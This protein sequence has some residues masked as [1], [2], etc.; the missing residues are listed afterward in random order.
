MT[1][2]NHASNPGDGGRVSNGGHVPPNAP[3]LVLAPANGEEGQ[4]WGSGRV[5][6]G[7]TRPSGAP[8]FTRPPDQ[9]KCRGPSASV[10]EQTNK[11]KEELDT[12]WRSGGSEAGRY[13]ARG[14]KRTKAAD[15]NFYADNK[16]IYMLEKKST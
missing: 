15:K 8:L 11:L 1:I 5:A 13:K 7:P 2:L 16:H 14:E 10:L 4:V 3:S 6:K 12:I 9:N